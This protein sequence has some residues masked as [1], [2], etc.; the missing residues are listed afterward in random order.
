MAKDR[1]DPPEM[2]QYTPAAKR[3]GTGGGGSVYAT[4]VTGL[5]YSDASDIDHYTIRLLTDT[6]AAWSAETTYAAGQYVI[7]SSKKYISA[8]NDNFNHDPE[9]AQ[10]A[11]WTLVPDIEIHES[12]L[13]KSLSRDLRYYVTWFTAGEI[14]KV[15]S[16]AVNGTTTYYLDETMTWAGSDAISSLRW[17][18]TANRARA[19]VV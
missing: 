5:S 1:F 16:E 3:G 6:T 18:E 12:W 11:W 15:K 7:K 19:V 14:I 10:S 2:A 13:D 8:A 4:I 17:S 9:E